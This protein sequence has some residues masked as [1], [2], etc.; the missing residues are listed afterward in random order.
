MTDQLITSVVTVLA[1]IMGV[2]IIAVIIS[3]KSNTAGVL[4]AGGNAFSQILTAA[5]G[6]GSGSLGNFG[7]SNFAGGGATSTS[8]G[9][10]FSL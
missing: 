9:G 1:A 4:Q 2:A 8:N 10:I 5:L 7:I 3:Q 6:Q